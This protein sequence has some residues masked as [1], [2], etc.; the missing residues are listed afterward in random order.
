MKG[1]FIA[2]KANVNGRLLQIGDDSQPI[3]AI[4]DGHRRDVAH[5]WLAGK[6]PLTNSLMWATRS[7]SRS[8]SDP[9][10]FAFIGQNLRS[11]WGIDGNVVQAIRYGPLRTR[12]NV[13]FATLQS[14][15]L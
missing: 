9:R 4:N 12:E 6:N 2:D 3:R 15:Q 7:K 11:F 10:L 1:P 14:M 13:H 8:A 5:C